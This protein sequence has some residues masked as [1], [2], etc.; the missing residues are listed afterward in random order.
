MNKGELI[1]AVV[2]KKPYRTRA[3]EVETIVNATLD[4]IKDALSKGENV[5]IPGFGTFKV[6][7][8]KARTGRN[9]RTGADIPIP[10]HG[11]V[12][13]SPGKSLKGMVK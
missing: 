2:G 6:E 12:K 5:K 7:Q 1:K 4:T 3:N 13:F 9:P 10:A 11:A 8:R